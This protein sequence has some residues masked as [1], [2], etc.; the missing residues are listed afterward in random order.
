MLRLHEGQP[1]TV[2]VRRDSPDGSSIEVRF[3]CK[4]GMGV[5]G[6]RAPGRTDPAPSS[7]YREADIDPDG[8]KVGRFI[9]VLANGQRQS[10][11]LSRL[12]REIAAKLADDAWVELEPLVEYGFRYLV[13]PDAALAASS[14]PAAVAVAATPEASGSVSSGAPAAAS[15]P[16]AAPAAEAGPSASVPR[17][18]PMA[19][20]LAREA[21]ASLDRDAAVRHLEAEMAK[22]ATLHA[23]VDRLGRE[24][25]RSAQRERDLLEL[26]RKWREA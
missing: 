25:E 20:S 18:T 23:E 3:E 24:L 11:A 2:S 19:P 15:A 22:V 16:T 14:A 17:Q 12:G 7:I 26:L 10:Y 9:H 21:L 4:D 8:L 13:V 5:L 6:I 1:F